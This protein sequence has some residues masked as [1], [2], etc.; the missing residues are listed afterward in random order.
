MVE[1]RKSG[2]CVLLGGEVAVRGG[3]AWGGE[4]VAAAW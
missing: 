1:T 2:E 4:A 3:C